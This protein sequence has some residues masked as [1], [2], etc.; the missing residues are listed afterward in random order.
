MPFS[1]FFL[2]FC[3]WGWFSSSLQALNPRSR[4]FDGWGVL[5]SNHPANQS[6]EMTTG[7]ISKKVISPS[8]PGQ[9]Q[10]RAALATRAG[11]ATHRMY[12]KK[13]GM[14]P[15][16]TTT[17]P[18]NPRCTPPK[19]EEK[20][21]TSRTRMLCER[22]FRKAK[23]HNRVK[24]SK[25]RFPGCLDQLTLRDDVSVLVNQQHKEEDLVSDRWH[26]IGVEVLLD[27]TVNG[28]IFVDH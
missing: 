12:P 26:V 17:N 3:A 8:Y 7:I 15:H 22:R 10:W 11:P 1:C 25:Y 5:T 2:Y 18:N 19:T 13:R 23:K 20:I 9:Q 6:S 16:I 21:K 14:T 4:F 24:V 28:K 27:S